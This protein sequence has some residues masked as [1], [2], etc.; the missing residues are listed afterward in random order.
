MP[1]QPRASAPVVYCTGIDPRLHAWLMDRLA[2]PPP[3]A[4]QGNAS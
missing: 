1:A 2:A 3:S 4:R